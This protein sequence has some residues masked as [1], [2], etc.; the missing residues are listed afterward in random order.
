MRSTVTAA[1]VLLEL[2]P[3]VGRA[4]NRHLESAKEWFPHEYAPYEAGRSFAEEPWQASD[5]RLSEIARLALELNLLTEDNLPYYHLAIWEMFGGAG[6]W[7][8]WARRWTA[9]EG[10][11][12]IAIRDYLML[13]RGVDPVALERGRMEHV[14]RG[15]YPKRLVGPL[16]GLVYVT[17]QELATRISH[18]NTGL[19]TGDPIAERLMTRVSVDENLHY[20]F[21]RDVASAAIELDPSA[22]VL[23]IRRQVLGFAMPGLELPGFREKAIRIASAGIYDLRI[24]HDQVLSPVLLKHWH[25]REL[26]GLNDEAELARDATI[27]FLE[28]L[29]ATAASAGEADARRH[30]APGDPRLSA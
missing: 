3:F 7:G 9:E 26:T 20:V 16:D 14:S 22:M 17:L 13:T 12:S 8:E 30:E 2:E 19:V 27:A 15:Y 10:R 25:L 1:N 6:P 28:Q 18:R 21:Y 23:A 4:L 29:D 24:H 5:S 11:H